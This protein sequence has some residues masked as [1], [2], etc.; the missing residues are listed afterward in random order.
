MKILR[1]SSHLLLCFA[2]VAILI[3]L[4]VWGAIYAEDQYEFFKFGRIAQEK[5]STSPTKYAQNAK[6]AHYL[7]QKPIKSVQ[8]T[9]DNQGSQDIFYYAAKING[10]YY[11]ITYLDRKD[12]VQLKSIQLIK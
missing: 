2:F 10:H 5:L 7:K 4:F 6:T 1:K 11:G 8:I 3:V 12:G 9:T